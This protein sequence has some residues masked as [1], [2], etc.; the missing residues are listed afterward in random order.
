MPLEIPNTP[1]STE[2][3]VALPRAAAQEG[4]PEFPRRGPVPAAEG[5]SPLGEANEGT[6]A[7]GGRAAFT[8]AIYATSGKGES[9]GNPQV[10]PGC[11]PIRRPQAFDYEAGA[12][13]IRT[14]GRCRW[15]A[16]NNMYD[17]RECT[18]CN[19]QSVAIIIIMR[20]DRRWL[21]PC[22]QIG[23]PLHI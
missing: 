11:I 21:P 2:G 12:C 3:R 17:L 19:M 4:H 1:A 18:R 9:V 14:L 20:C 10:P 6:R 23:T 7:K 5:N 13:R 22:Q 8:K 15:L 16:R